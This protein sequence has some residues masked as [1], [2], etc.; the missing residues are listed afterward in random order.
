MTR[1][2]GSEQKALS[3]GVDGLF[4][5][6][7]SLAERCEDFCADRGLDAGPLKRK[8]WE[9][10]G[11]RPL[12]DVREMWR[13]EKQEPGHD[14]SRPILRSPLG[15]RPDDD[16]ACSPTRS[17]FPCAPWKAGSR[18][19]PLHQS[20]RTQPSRKPRT[21]SVVRAPAF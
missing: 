3:S 19:A 12:I 16:Q 10:H 13:E 5:A 1:A 18:A 8:L 14:A 6:E 4:E 21:C 7:P 11:V 20:Q 15:S 17:E 9:V 2:S